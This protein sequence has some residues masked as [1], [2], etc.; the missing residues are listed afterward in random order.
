MAKPQPIRIPS[1]DCAVT[2]GGEKYHPHEGEW[3]EMIPGLTVGALHG[4]RVLQ[5]MVPQ[6]Q[7]A[8]GEPGEQARVVA[9]MDTGYAEI[10]SFLAAR[11]FGWN[12]TDLSGR[13]LPAP[14]GTP[15]ALQALSAEEVNW[16]LQ[17]AGGETPAAQK[18]GSKR[19]PTTS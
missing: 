6:L 1:D 13:P 5:E 10:C 14:D 19:S 18:K 15:S 3:V 4:M 7:A 8:E 2:I 9:L 17:A 12:W 11:L 16:L